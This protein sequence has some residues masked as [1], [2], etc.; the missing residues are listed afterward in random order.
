MKRLDILCI[1]MFCFLS[2]HAQVSKISEE[3]AMGDQ[4]FLMGN[5]DGAQKAYKRAIKSKK[6]SATLWGIIEH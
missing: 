1:L 6:L 5:I 3:V 4:Q 2:I